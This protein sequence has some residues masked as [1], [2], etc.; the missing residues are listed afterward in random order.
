MQRDQKDYE[1]IKQEAESGNP[2]AMLQLS[3]LFRLGVFQDESDEE[4]IYWL[5]EFFKNEI[6]D[7]F[8]TVLD[9]DDD[10]DFDEH[11]YKSQEIVNAIG[12]EAEAVL[13]KDIIE[14]GLSLGLFLMYSTNKEELFCARESLDNAL[15]ASRFDYI[16]V[17]G[18]EGI[19]D[20]NSIR[21][22][23]DKRI[24]AFGYE[25]EL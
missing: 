2:H 24:K 12:F 7:A 5:K 14:A 3:K 20:V 6:V 8:L 13:Q 10:I 15:I 1:I 22:T 18:A 16:E 19:T 4:Y 17:P 11:F 9:A 23:I 21:I 25:E